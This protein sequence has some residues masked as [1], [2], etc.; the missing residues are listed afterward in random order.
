MQLLKALLPTVHAS[1]PRYGSEPYVVAADIYGG[2]EKGGE[3]GWTWYSG[4][5]SWIYRTGID[6]I[7]GLQFKAGDRLF[8]DPAIPTEWPKY[9]ARY[10]KG[11]T[12]SDAARS[13]A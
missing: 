8:I 9:S 1:D 6:S 4:G 11:K 5:P 10:L 3:G 13:D 2:K 12:P 7:L